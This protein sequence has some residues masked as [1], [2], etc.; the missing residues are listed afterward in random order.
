SLNSFKHSINS[1]KEIN[2]NF[3]NQALKFSK[4]VSKN[5]HYNAT[6][7]NISFI[8]GICLLL[9]GI[10]WWVIYWSIF[11]FKKIKKVKK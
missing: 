5:Y 6:P 11:V 1:L 10:V 7:E 3:Y 4:T 2:L 8:A 9:I